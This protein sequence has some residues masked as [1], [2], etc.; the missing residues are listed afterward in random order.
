MGNPTISSEL[1]HLEHVPI[2][3][4]TPFQGDLKELSV[5]NYKKLKGQILENG[6]IVPFYVWEHDATLFILDGHQRDRV[7]TG[8]GWDIDVPVIRIQAEHEQD[9]K[10]KLLAISSQYGKVTQE[11]WDEFTYDLDEGWALDNV[12]FD[13]LPFVFTD[14]GQAEDESTGDDAEAQ[15]NRADE[16]QKKWGTE[17]GQLWILPSRDGEGEHRLICGDCTDAGTVGA[18]MGGDLADIIFTDP[19]YGVSVA[20]GSHDPRDKKNYQ[21]GGKI[22][23]DDLNDAD[24]K[25]LWEDSLGI[26]TSICELGSPVYICFSDSRIKPCL[27]GVISAGIRYSQLI[28]WAKQKMV[29]SRKDYHSQHEPIFYGWVSGAAHNAPSSRKL[30]TLWEIDRP[31][32]SDKRHPTQK[33]TKLPQTAIGNH[34]SISI[35]YDPFVGSGTTIIAAENLSRYCRAVEISPSYCAVILQRYQDAFNITPHLGNAGKLTDTT[36]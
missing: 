5:K 28:I 20:G 6:I 4:L 31:L 34:N 1:S 18:M 12:H 7:F 17:T 10:K 13:A 15:T 36:L 2:S 25:K 23:G 24:L 9:A 8:E 32:R 16:L 14:L 33:P 26:A 35:V 19:P 11:G 22:Q 29:F 3:A 21:S 30:T 27:D